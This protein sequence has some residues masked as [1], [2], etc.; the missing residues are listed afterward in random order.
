MKRY[1]CVS[2]YHS[3]ESNYLSKSYLLVDSES[4]TIFIAKEFDCEED[5]EEDIKKQ[6]YNIEDVVFFEL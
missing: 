1:I 5:I 2:T 6:G 4:Q 3:D